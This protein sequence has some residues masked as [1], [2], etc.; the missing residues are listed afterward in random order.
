MMTAT[1]NK[2]P[3]K[4]YLKHFVSFLKQTGIFLPKPI[5]NSSFAK[6]QKDY[7]EAC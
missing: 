1:F 7:N 3:K 4:L 5:E 6:T 2:I